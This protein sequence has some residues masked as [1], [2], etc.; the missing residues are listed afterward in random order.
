M[1]PRNNATPPVIDLGEIVL[2][3][4]G[5]QQTSGASARVKIGT[6]AWGAAAGSLVCDATSGIWTYAPTQ[7]ETNADYFIV[8]AYKA[9]CTSISKTIVTTGSSTSGR[10]LLSSETHTNAVIPTVTTVTNAITLPS[11]PANWITAAGINAG[12][13]DGK[14]NWNVGKT[15]YSL[16]AGSGLGNQTANITGSMSG[17][18]GSVTGNVGSLTGFSQATFETMADTIAN[19]LDA[20]ITSRMA[21][22]TYTAPPTSA[23]I[24]DAV[25]DEAISGHLSAGSTGNAL[26][27]AGS[28]G[29]PWTTTLPGAYGAGTAGNI[30]GNRI[31]AAVTSRMATFTYTVPPT[32]AAVAD[33]VWDELL[34]GH[35]IAGSAG[36]GLTAAGSAGDPWS[37]SLPGAYG[38]GT[39]GNIIGNRIDAAVT[40]RM[41][42]YTQP[43]GFL[44]GNFTV[45]TQLDA[46][47]SSRMA[48]FAYTAPPTTSAIATQVRSELATELARID[49]SISSRLASAS[50]SAPSSAAAIAAQVRSELA[51]ELA[52]LDAAVS[53]RLAT[54]SYSSP[55]AA[56]TIAAQVRTELAAELAR[57]D[58]DV[59]SRL[60]AAGYT[61][62]TTAGA[63]A[64]AVWDEPASE[65]AT[66]G[67]F[68]TALADA[69]THAAAVAGKFTGITFLARWLRLMA[70]KTADATTLTEFQADAATTFNNVTDS[71]ESNR[72]AIAGVSGG[73]SGPAGAYAQT[74][75]VKRSD[76]D[77]LVANAVV[78][79]GDAGVAWTG[80]TN[81]SG[82]VELGV[83]A[84]T[85]VVT[86][87][88]SGFS[89]TPTSKTVAGAEAFELLVVPNAITPAP[90]AEECSCYVRVYFASA[91]ESS[92]LYA[93][94]T[95]SPSG[96]AGA[97]WSGSSRL[98]PVTPESG[99]NPPSRMV[100]IMLVRGATYQLRRDHGPEVSFTVPDDSSAALPETLGAR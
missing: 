12:A 26:N 38:A 54:A 39:A 18:V 9:A 77:A 25:W 40:S 49:A 11:I 30:I 86:V 5:T 29:D 53:S 72:D 44:A 46:A 50:Y 71:L 68:G 61:A 22:F 56:A 16:T 43:T 81:G 34:S 93:R 36:A 73:G 19:N 28:A 7:A 41:A 42:T 15:G 76:T 1:Y 95:A 75:T 24:A 4:D 91:G 74:V 51:T 33:A 23:A 80:T 70:G 79:I 2:K 55:I 69:L 35:V 96:A 57:I 13:L 45:L 83:D 92:T 66:A 58:A 78:R 65:H 31:D 62:P 84:G 67:T 64:D 32:S 97:S 90:S 94:L 47:V 17:S 63:I 87:S 48:T 14:G 82:V 20:T 37:A 85:Y 100:E 10:A 89:Y 52:R 59:S 60:A 21:T 98:I 88:A 99:S 6:G 3:S 8:A 27:A